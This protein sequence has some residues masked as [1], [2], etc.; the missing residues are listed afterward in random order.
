MSDAAHGYCVISTMSRYQLEH[1]G[2]CGTFYGYVYLDGTEE[3][4]P[5][6]PIGYLDVAE[7]GD[8]KIHVTGWALDYDEP[9]TALEVHVYIGGAYGDSAIEG[10]AI[11]ADKYRDDVPIALNN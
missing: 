10:R 4:Y 3:D 11:K 9:T 6:N 5:H 8:G 2:G 7:G 1:Q